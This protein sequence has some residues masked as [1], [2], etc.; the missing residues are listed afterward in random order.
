M[1]KFIHTSEVRGKI[2]APASKSQTIRAMIG[3]VLSESNTKIINPLYCHDTE[4]VLSIIQFFR[5]G[6]EESE[7]LL[8]ISGGLKNI[9]DIIN[10]GESATCVRIFSAIAL[11]LDDYIKIEGR[12]TLLNRDFSDVVRSLNSIGIDCTSN[13]GLLP[14][15]IKGGKAFNAFKLD[16]SQSSQFLSGLLF[17][18]PLLNY[19]TDILANN[20]ISKSYIDLTIE[21]LNKFNISVIRQ[22]DDRF[23]IEGNQ[24]YESTEIEIE[25]DW[26]NAAYL[27]VAGAIGGYIDL[28]G[29][30]INSVQGD[31]KILEIINVCGSGITLKSDSIEI[32]KG[33]LLGFIYDASD[34]PDLFP[35]LVALAVNCTGESRIKGIHRLRNKESDRLSSL[36]EEFSKLGAV[37]KTENNTMIIEG[38]ILKGGEVFSHNDHRIAMSLAIAGINSEKPVVIGNSECVSKSYPDFFGD[39][40]QIGVKINE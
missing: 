29:L 22:N 17:T 1:K 26:S 28:Y 36:T 33:H 21:I 5:A 16:C 6:I 4:T 23:K 35:P 10:C 7:N 38:G 9:P 15:K 8:A 40:K 25:G 34:T 13:N 20:L 32:K 27:L 30:N 19:D 24:K 31:K 37:I 14:L 2:T 18:L 39:L 11:L 3:A 12:G